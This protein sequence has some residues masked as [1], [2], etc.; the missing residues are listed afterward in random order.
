MKAHVVENGVVINSI[1][2]D[3]L[4][5]MSNLIADDGKAG[6]GWSYVNGIFVDNRPAPE[7]DTNQ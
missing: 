7:Q 4:D 5:F 3:S 6:I 2:V 1:E